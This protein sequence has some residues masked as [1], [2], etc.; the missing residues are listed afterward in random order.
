MSGSKT[1]PKDGS[2]LWLPLFS[3]LIMAPD[4]GGLVNERHAS[5]GKADFREMETSGHR[6]NLPPLENARPK[7]N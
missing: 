7:S 3:S 5:L 4:L 2:V 6:I 1:Y